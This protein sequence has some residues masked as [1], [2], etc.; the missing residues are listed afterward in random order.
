MNRSQAVGISDIQP[1]LPLRAYPLSQWIETAPSA[2]Q[3]ALRRAIRATGQIQM[4]LPHPYEDTVTMAG[5][6]VRRLLCQPANRRATEK[7]HYLVAGTETGV[8]NSKALSAYIMEALAQSDTPLP[9]RLSNFQVQHACASGTIA[10]FSL[11]ALLQLSCDPQESAIVVCS[12]IAHYRQSAAAE[13]TQGAGAVG[14]LISNSPRLLDL[15]ISTL[16]HASAGVDDFFRPLGSP[17]A[18]V[19]GGYSIKCYHRALEVAMQDFSERC[20]R[21]T[22]QILQESDYVV[23]HSP[24]KSMAR[25][26]IHSL[27]ANHTDYTPQQINAYI[28]G[29]GLAD[30]IEPIGMVGNIYSA[31][32]YFVLYCLF[33]QQYRKIGAEIVGRRVLIC[34]YGS[35]YTMTIMHGVIAAEAPAVIEQ[36][37]VNELLSQTVTMS[38]E[39]YKR[40]M[41]MPYALHHH[42]L[43]SPTAPPTESGV[44]L[45]T[46]REDGYREYRFHNA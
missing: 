19:K 44:Y 14:L 27:L 30:A 8:D 32:V 21:S 7:L 42:D 43:P 41:R 23:M 28:E 11:C 34:S 12:D 29:R 37:D 40:W 9:E 2:A 25:N 31:S 26:A 24:F 10:L 45:H 16:G 18:K 38:D 5:N 35:G 22:Q 13:I 33:A 36:W 20:G 39:E 17:D 4:R 6:A 15:D 3:G 1:F 46:I